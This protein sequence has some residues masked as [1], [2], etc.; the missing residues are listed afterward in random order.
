MLAIVVAK[1]KCRNKMRGKTVARKN[2]P[3]EVSRR[4]FLA[5]VAMT[6]AATAA[7]ATG[8]GKPSAAVEVARPAA[9]RPST[10]AA[11]AELATQSVRV[12]PGTLPGRPGS[13][14]MV[15]VLKSLQIDF[16][17]S[18]PASSCRGIHESIV[19]YGGNKKP[20]FITCMHEESAVAMTHGYY[21]V[22]G[23]PA[24]ALCHGTV[25]LQ[26]AA[27]AVYNAWCDRAASIVMVGNRMDAATRQPGV[28]TIHA[29]QDPGS[30]IRDFTKWDDNPQSL[31]HFAESMV[32]AYKVTMTPPLE[33]VLMVL[34]EK[35]QEDAIES[36]GRPLVIP[37]LNNVAP[38]AGDPNAVR[39]AARLL[40]LAEN[41][42]IVV[43]RVGRT[44]A[45]VKHLVELAEALNAPVI[46]QLGR[47]NMPNNHPLYQLGGGGL[48]ERA[49]VILGLELTDFWGTVNNSD[50]SVEMAQVYRP[51]AGAR[52]IS[53]GMGDLYIRANY[54]DF[55]RY[56]QVDIAIGADAETTLPML[57]EYIRQ[58][59]PA[60][61]RAKIAER[62]DKA[63]KGQAEAR[64]RMLAQ[65]AANAWDASPVSSARLS[66]EIWQQIK[67]ENWAL[68][69]RDSSLSNWPHR[70]WT[71]DQHHQFIG[72]PGGAGIGYGL[73][74]AVGA[75]F[76]HREADQRLCVNIQNDGDSMYA[77]GALW[78]AAHH[79]VPMLTIMWNNRAYHQEIMHLQR[80]ANW[81]Q[82]GIENPHIGTT[83]RD[84]YINYAKLAEALGHVGIG[85]I[86]DPKDLAVAIKRG[87][88]AVKM[89]EP[90]LID[91]V[92]Q[93][94]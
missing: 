8:Q 87:L 28:P 22:A 49:D 73:P 38:P 20:E 76:A 34:D 89:G 13:D 39:E 32:R 72:G 17:F 3:T 11:Q 45:G 71:F 41:P 57:T 92:T 4:K 82:R 67:N 58:A 31:Q 70:L 62:G 43:D 88:D 75:A 60:D 18:N 83:I 56:Q 61:R 52:L 69:S 81:R 14:F 86:T 24:A 42:V 77:P 21:K 35:L 68:V 23:K 65:A 33:P 29:V 78:T 48:I 51:K 66:A 59:I 7:S 64:Q 63:R 9:T 37:R 5:G 1:R 10:V 19:T 16:V 54:Q 44:P 30:L 74:A 12:A 27:M 84:P 25:G 91:V 46:D 90:V 47:M 6:G 26:H 40:A 79:K 55:E 15:D 93:P 2:A 94:R 36:G 53:I 80:M 85:P 50:D